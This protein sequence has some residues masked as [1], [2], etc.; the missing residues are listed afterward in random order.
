M[1]P[2]P[3]Y[4]WKHQTP[5]PSFLGVDIPAAALPHGPCGPA[6]RDYRP[7]KGLEGEASWYDWAVYEKGVPLG[8]NGLGAAEQGGRGRQPQKSPSHAHGGSE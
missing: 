6:D 1:L 5:I 3:R 7:A 2:I 4:D 8:P